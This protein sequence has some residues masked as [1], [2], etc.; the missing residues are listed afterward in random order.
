[1]PDS[2]EPL[3][4]RDPGLTDV[5]G[6]A[7][8]LSMWELL[9][10]AQAPIEAAVLADATGL[11]LDVVHDGLD[12]LTEARL[13][14]RVKATARRRTPRWRVTRDV[15]VVGYR[16]GDPI[17][18][19]LIGCVNEL[20]G[21]TR[22]EHLRSR[23]LPDG[24]AH[25]SG[26]WSR[27]W[28]GVFRREDRRRFWELMQELS[29]LYHVSSSRF[30]GA[31]PSNAQQCTHLIEI[32]LEPLR[33]GV[34]RLPR[35]RMRSRG[36]ASRLDGPTEGAARE[37]LVGRA[38]PDAS[39]ERADPLGE[40]EREIAGRIVAG[41]TR[42]EIGHDLGIAPST[43]AT[44]ARNLYRKLG[45]SSRRELRDR[46]SDFGRAE[47]VRL[48]L[49]AAGAK[50]SPERAGERS[51]EPIG[52]GKPGVAAAL[53]NAEALAIW[54]H[55]R[56]VGREATA[57]E[58]AEAFGWD[59]DVVEER[60]RL[61]EAAGGL[62]VER[63]S[64]PKR[65]GDPRWRVARG[66]IVI[67]HRADDP[68]DQAIVARIRRI[69]EADRRASI[70]SQAK[71]FEDRAADEEIFLGMQVGS[72]NDEEL[73]RIGE[74]LGELEEAFA[75]S[76]RS[77]AKESASGPWSTYHVSIDVMPLGAGVAP[78]PTMNVVGREWAPQLAGNLD[79]RL[80]SLS[81][82]ERAVAFALRDGL[83]RRRIAESLGVS[84]HTVATLVKRLY[85]K[86]GIRSRR[87]LA[88]RLGMRGGPSLP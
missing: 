17:D 58:I 25:A 77:A 28:A 87:D 82:R 83:D 40:R 65:M 46:M 35:I 12:R 78:Q 63:V 45:V 31:A 64:A 44:H 52:L 24:A 42:A 66:S 51:P 20:F 7:D 18:E 88:R 2:N 74:I 1:M 59:R 22:R 71:S 19:V 3:D 55:L 70:R 30:L 53:M 50:A 54:E 37:W 62:L 13:A 61:L 47:F 34:P 73:R 36:E 43:V 67:E 85:A 39:A 26:R 27:V 86:L 72:F 41:R 76:D 38:E 69:F 57:T 29:R 33:P 32:A 6:D 56:V 23:A 8:A 60:L 79:D 81:K 75:C 5:L 15:I 4:I 9:R 16:V 84:P 14:E 48:P 68:R 21:P 80:A 10:R 49:E 11:R